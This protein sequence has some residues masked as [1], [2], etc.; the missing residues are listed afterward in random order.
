MFLLSLYIILASLSS[1]FLSSFIF[2]KLL[3][4]HV[5]STFQNIVYRLFILYIIP[6]QTGRGHLDTAALQKTKEYLRM[7]HPQPVRAIDIAQYTGK[8]Q[9]RAARL[10]DYFSGDCGENE[11]TVTDFL[12]YCN[13]EAKP[14]TYNIFL[15]RERGIYA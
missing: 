11:N 12:I 13:D 4:T 7:K 1:L 15:D 9:A 14:T 6:M 3:I 2:P 10:L 8:S 5:F